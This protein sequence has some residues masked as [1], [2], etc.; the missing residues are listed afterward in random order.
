MWGGKNAK[1]ANIAQQAMPTLRS[2]LRL[3]RCGPSV[4][5][6]KV[7]GQCD[8]GVVTKAFDLAK[9]WV[10]DALSSINDVIS[11]PDEANLA[12]DQTPKG[13]Q[14]VERR[15]RTV[16]HL[17]H[18]FHITDPRSNKG[19]VSKVAEAFSKLN[20]A[21]NGPVPFQCEQGSGGETETSW[22]PA[23]VLWSPLPPTFR[24][25][26]HLYRGFFS[27]EQMMS[28][29]F[30]PGTK[31]DPKKI[32]DEEKSKTVQSKLDELALYNRATVIIHEMTHKYLHTSDTAS[33][34]T[35]ADPTETL[36]TGKAKVYSK[37]TPEEAL[38]NADSYSQF[39]RHVAAQDDPLA[40]LQDLK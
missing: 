34:S 9:Q 26:I 27:D 17:E 11:G 18:D 23:E 6:P 28:G 21:F 16:R 38:D 35:G 37:L 29:A 3:Q 5:G 24:G 7:G 15:T 33:A 20:E 40:F 8:T 22:V 12:L 13:M 31:P 2:G 4:P 25:D 19:Q 39:A 1:L 36:T 10:S 32:A 30:A 14:R